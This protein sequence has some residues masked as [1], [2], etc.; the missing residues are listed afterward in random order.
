MSDEIEALRA[1]IDAI[2][3]EL[4]DA[5]ARRARLVDE[6]AAKKKTQGLRLRDPSRE[7]AI[8]ERATRRA[9]A[10]LSAAAIER[11]IAAT[12]A[13]CFPPDEPTG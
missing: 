3:D 10:R 5:L 11:F 4:I 9:P 6:V 12:L 7:A 13:A 2:D 1:R 8:L